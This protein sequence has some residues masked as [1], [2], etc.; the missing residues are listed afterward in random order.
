[1]GR[2]FVRRLPPIWPFLLWLVVFYSVWLGIVA[3]G[4]HWGTL[5]SHWPIALTMSLGSYVAGS[6]PMGGG[7]VAFPV[8]VLLFE[9]PGALGRNFGL[10]IQS[11]GMTSA[12]IYI[13]ST[14]RPVDW[15]LLRPALL[16]SLIGTPLG[17]AFIAP[18]VPDLWVK[19]IFGVIWASFGIMHLVKLKE[20]TTNQGMHHRSKSFDPAI[21]LTIGIFGGIASSIT[22]VGI[23]MMIYATLVLLYRSD[24]KIAI[25]TSVILMAFTSLVGIGSNVLLSQISPSQFAIAPEVYTNWLA[26]APIVALGA[27][28]GA[29]VV[30]LISRTPTLVVV[31]ILC[32]GQFIWTLIHEHVTG[33]ALFGALVGVAVFILLFQALYSAAKFVKRSETLSDTARTGDML[34]SFDE[35]S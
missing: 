2:F 24:L 35:A 9:M 18:Y 8:L 12:A 5:A 31:S 19:L 26:A 33:V 34:E 4:N 29:L 10:A 11:I 17:A 13:M 16:G 28:F 21:G 1:M 7:T 20:L 6:T 15:G 27:P 14:H 30:N 25:P 32:I 23:D 3:V 22:G